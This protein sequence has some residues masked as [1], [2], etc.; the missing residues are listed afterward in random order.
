MSTAYTAVI[1]KGV[2]VLRFPIPAK[3]APSKSAKTLLV[4]NTAGFTKISGLEHDGK[5]VSLNVCATIPIA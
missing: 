3:L 2:L 1:E 4:A 5:Q